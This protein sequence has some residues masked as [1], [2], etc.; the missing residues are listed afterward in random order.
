MSEAII[1][2]GG[3]GTRLRGVVSG[4]PKPMAPI[5]GKPFLEYLLRSL[6]SQG[7]N[8]FILS[9]GYMGNIIREYFGDNFNGVEITYSEEEF[10]LGTG[11]ATKQ[12]LSQ[13]SQDHA[14]I[15]NGDTYTEPNIAMMGSL[16][17][18]EANTI[19]MGVQVENVYRY[20]SL[21]IMEESNTIVGFDEKGANKPGIINAGCYVIGKNSLDDFENDMKFSLEVDYFPTLISSGKL[22]VCISRGHFIDI[23]IPEDYH[24]AV[25]FLSE[26]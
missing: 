9:T 23:G 13:V 20:G 6:L 7:I 16:W 12:A 21:N 4:V 19:V 14:F 25:N 10:P 26:V 22:K 5:G 1:L 8:H 17:K 18:H 3:F 2:V 24:K 15:L 11:G